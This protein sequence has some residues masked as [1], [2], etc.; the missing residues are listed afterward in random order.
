MADELTSSASASG[1]PRTVNGVIKTEFKKLQQ[2]FTSQAFF[3]AR[4]LVHQACELFFKQAVGAAYFLFFTKLRSV[5][6][7]LAL[8]SMCVLT[9]NTGLFRHDLVRLW[10]HRVA[11]AAALFYDRRRI[12]C[13]RLSP[14]CLTWAN[15][16]MWDTCHVFN[17]FNGDVEVAHGADSGIAAESNT[18]YEYID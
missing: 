9:G 11:F 14:P 3:A 8:A 13:H 7:L 4:S 6:T 2:V 10:V 15:T 1:K 18:L 16:T 12:S 17:T 5:K